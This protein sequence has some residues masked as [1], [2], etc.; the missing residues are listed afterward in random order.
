MCFCAKVRG[1]SEAGG[2]YKVVG[3]VPVLLVPAERGRGI[4]I[5]CSD[6]VAPYPGC[7]AAESMG[8]KRS[9]RGECRHSAT[10]LF[11]CDHERSLRQQM[12]AL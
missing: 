2:A 6:P 5:V 4:D 3:T 9:R 8:H 10:P 1:T 12:L 7:F 11:K